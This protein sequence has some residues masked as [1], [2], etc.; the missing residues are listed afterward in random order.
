MEISVDAQN[1][2]QNRIPGWGYHGH[3]QCQHPAPATQEPKICSVRAYHYP[4]EM[5]CM[6]VLTSG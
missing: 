5:R 1:E 6:A 2:V 4:N 3:G